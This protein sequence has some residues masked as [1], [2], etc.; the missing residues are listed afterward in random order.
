M[1]THIVIEDVQSDDDEVDSATDDENDILEQLLHTYCFTLNMAAA[2]LFFSY[3]AV[4]ASHF[5]KQNVLK[6]HFCSFSGKTSYLKYVGY[7]C[8]IT[9]QKLFVH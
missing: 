7:S 6:V 5:I 9:Q 2:K 4:I 3:T 1:C 8:E